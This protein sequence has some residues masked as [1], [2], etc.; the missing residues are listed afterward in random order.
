[1]SFSLSFMANERPPRSVARIFVLNEE[2]Q[3]LIQ[4]I[5]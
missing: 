5:K 1:M 2:Q 4:L 3:R